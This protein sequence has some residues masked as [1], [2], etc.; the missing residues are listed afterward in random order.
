MCFAL[1][2]VCFV[3]FLLVNVGPTHFTVFLMLCHQ[4]EKHNFTTQSVSNPGHRCS[5]SF[6]TSSLSSFLFPS[7]PFYLPTSLFSLLLFLS[8][9]VAQLFFNKSS[10]FKKN[11]LPNWSSH[12][13]WGMLAWAEGWDEGHSLCSIDIYPRVCLFYSHL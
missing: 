4:E 11:I 7:L 3:L 5:S 12:C 9:L 8:I 13:N 6:S 2:S 10:F 1:F